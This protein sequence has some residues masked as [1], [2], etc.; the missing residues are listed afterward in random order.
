MYCV[1]VPK[2]K[3]VA[4][5]VALILH[6]EETA[7]WIALATMLLPGTAQSIVTHRQA[8]YYPIEIFN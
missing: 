3:E 4:Y 1:F 7:I 2:I 5:P 6:N 8:G